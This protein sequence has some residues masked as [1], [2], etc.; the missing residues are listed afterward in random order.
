MY[1]HNFIG[2][3]MGH[4]HV[5]KTKRHFRDFFETLICKCKRTVLS[6][7]SSLCASR[8]NLKDIIAKGIFKK[9]DVTVGLKFKLNSFK[10]IK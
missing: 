7:E 9:E 5:S 2:T 1:W 8:H 6:G 10:R 3:F 4:C